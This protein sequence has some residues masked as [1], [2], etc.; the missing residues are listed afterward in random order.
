MGLITAN[1]GGRP[2]G[3][4]F[5]NISYVLYPR[6]K[7]VN[8]LR[9]PSKNRKAQSAMEYLMTYGWGILIIAVVLGAL[10]SL[11]VFNGN[12]LGTACVAA[13]GYYCQTP[14]YS[15]T[16]GNIIVTVGQSTGTNWQTA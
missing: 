11:G 8:M 6:H 1:A 16:T 10:F 4:R 12:S 9:Q 3:A 7:G 2:F 15:H 14:I 5:L 13:S